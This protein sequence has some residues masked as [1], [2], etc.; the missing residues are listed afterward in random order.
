MNLLVLSPLVLAFSAPFA[1]VDLVATCCRWDGSQPSQ[2]SHPLVVNGCCVAAY[3]APDLLHCNT[4][5]SGKAN[6]YNCSRLSALVK[7]N[8]T[9]AQ[10]NRVARSNVPVHTDEDDD[11]HNEDDEDDEDLVN[12]V[13]G[14]AV[15]LGVLLLLIV[16]GWYT[17][18]IEFTGGISTKTY[19]TVN[20]M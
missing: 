2:S 14:L 17:K 10:H 9:A 6:E 19:T 11:E 5:S 12:T 7:N 1:D 18:R 8:D 15:T 20:V 4:T 13:I 3:F 16:V